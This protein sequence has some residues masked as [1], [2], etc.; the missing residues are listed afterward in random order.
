[1]LAQP[2]RPRIKA[3]TMIPLLLNALFIV[4]SLN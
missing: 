4:Y 1:V 2:A 3:A